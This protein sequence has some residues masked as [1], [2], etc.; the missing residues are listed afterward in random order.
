LNIFNDLPKSLKIHIK[1]GLRY[2]EPIERTIGQWTL[3]K[4]ALNQSRNVTLGRVPNDQSTSHIGQSTG[5]TILLLT[6]YCFGLLFSS[7][8]SHTT[9][10]SLTNM[11]H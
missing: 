2:V 10:G 11:M 5:S 7:L 3:L 1:S 9:S 6:E 4:I 8:Q